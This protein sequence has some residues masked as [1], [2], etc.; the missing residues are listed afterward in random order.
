MLVKIFTLKYENGVACESNIALVK[1]IV[2]AVAT[3]TETNLHH[4]PSHF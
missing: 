2:L 1:I 4:K 3:K